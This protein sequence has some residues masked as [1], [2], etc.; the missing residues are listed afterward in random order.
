MLEGRTR[1]SVQVWLYA[2]VKLNINLEAV[3][4]TNRAVFN[5]VLY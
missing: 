2:Y 5:Y 3:I 1:E 4:Y